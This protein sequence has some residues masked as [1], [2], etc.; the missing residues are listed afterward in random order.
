MQ[1]LCKI[2]C[3]Y[4]ENYLDSYDIWDTFDYIV[5]VPLHKKRLKERGYNQSELIA[6]EVAEYLKIPMHTDLLIRTKATK[7]QSSLVRTERVTN[8]QSAFK[9]TEKCDGKKIIAF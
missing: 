3:R 2:T 9:C 7:K 6:K 5:P 8:V 4:D 1:S